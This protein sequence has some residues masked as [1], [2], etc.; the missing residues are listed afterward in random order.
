M[1]GRAT[2]GGT[3]FERGSRGGAEKESGWSSG[4]GLCRKI[5]SVCAAIPQ[6]DP[7][8]SGFWVAYTFILFGWQL[9]PI[10]ALTSLLCSLTD[11]CSPVWPICHFVCSEP[12]L[13]LVLY[14]C[15]FHSMDGTSKCVF[16]SFLFVDTCY[17]REW[18]FISAD[19]LGSEIIWIWN[20]FFL[21]K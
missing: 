10:L 19:V 6:W 18:W 9:C 20:S 16:F 13:V 7:A 2:E 17:L 12:S 8:S 3:K 4:W 5:Y 14:C 1:T 11:S 15:F 21:M